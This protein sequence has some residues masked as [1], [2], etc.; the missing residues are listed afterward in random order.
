MGADHEYVAH[1]RVV[2]EFLHKSLAIDPDTGRHQLEKVLHSV[3]F[4]MKTTS[5]DVTL[6]SQN[7]WLVDE[8]LSFHVYLASD[9][10][11]K[12][13]EPL[14][15]GEL[16]RPDI[17]VVND[18]DSRLFDRTHVL[19][20]GTAYPLNSFVV[21]EFKRPNHMDY[22]DDNPITQV[23]EQIEKIRDS[24]FKDKRGRYIQLSQRNVP[25]YAF[26]VCDIASAELKRFARSAMLQ[27]S[28]DGQ[29][30]FGYNTAPE[31]NAYVEIISYDKLIEDAKK[32]NRVLFDRMGLSTAYED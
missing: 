10:S 22:G 14:D 8:R 26:I 11:L 4:P 12:S 19:A 31:I 32:R 1:R 28:P 6:D 29:G 2:I 3:V 20:E 25:A 7:L 5:E 16:T 18:F 30:F 24:K 9:K 27:P 15:S 17:F 13:M 23:Y 21:V